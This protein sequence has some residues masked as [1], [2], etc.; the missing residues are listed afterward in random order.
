[1]AENYLFLKERREREEGVEAEHQRRIGQARVQRGACEY[2]SMQGTKME[3]NST[4]LE[5]QPFFARLSCNPLI[6]RS[7]H[8]QKGETW[9]KGVT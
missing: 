9:F 3:P 1:M 7:S 5:P 2:V 4:N 8:A 6:N